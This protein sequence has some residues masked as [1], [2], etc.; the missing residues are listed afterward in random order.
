MKGCKTA[1]PNPRGERERERRREEG[2]PPPPPFYLAFVV[3]LPLAPAAPSFLSPQPGFSPPCRLRGDPETPL[4]SPGQT[5]L[6]GSS[7]WAPPG[8]TGEEGAGLARETPP[9]GLRPP[10][11]SLPLDKARV[12]RGARL[13]LPAASQAS[14]GKRSVEALK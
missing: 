3:A 14:L 6:R 4:L 7:A 11:G 8:E 2:E 5:E 1:P 9:P 12:L 13:L 10:A